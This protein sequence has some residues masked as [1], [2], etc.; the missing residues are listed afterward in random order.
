MARALIDGIISLTF[1]CDCPYEITQR[2]ECVAFYNA[3]EDYWQCPA[4]KQIFKVGKSIRL[5][6]V[7]ELKI[8]DRLLKPSGLQLKKEK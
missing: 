7:N 8:T 6:K 1:E 3:T 4:C 2:V 5:S